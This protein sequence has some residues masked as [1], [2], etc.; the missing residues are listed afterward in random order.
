MTANYSTSDV[1]AVQQI[2]DELFF[3][4]TNEP[5][6]LKETL[7][8]IKS[9]VHQANIQADKLIEADWFKDFNTYEVLTVLQTEFPNLSWKAGQTNSG[10]SFTSQLGQLHIEIDYKFNFLSSLVKGGK[11]EPYWKVDVYLEQPDWVITL[12]KD[13]PT[14]YHLEVAIYHIKDTLLSVKEV[15]DNLQVG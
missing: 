9:L 12:N 10:Y 3:K 13:N 1:S 11:L 8:E 2:T 7:K 4:Y 14:F 5:Y 6:Y 15:F